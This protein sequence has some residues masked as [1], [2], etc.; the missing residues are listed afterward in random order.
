MYDNSNNVS[1]VTDP[2]GQLTTETSYS[3]GN[4]YTIQQ[5]GFNVFGESLG[6][7]VTLP[8]AEGALAG[9]YT[10][11]HTYTATTGLPVQRHLPRLARRRRAA[12]RDRRPRLR[13]RVR[14]ARRT[15]Q[16]LAA[17]AQNITYN[18]FSQ[19]AQEE[20]GS[21]TNHA[22]ITNTYDPHTG[23][24]TDSQIENTAVSAT[25][26]D[27]T[28]YSYDPAGNITAQTDTRNGTQPKPSASATT[29]STGS[30]RP[31]PP[32]TTAP[33]TPPA[34]SGATVGD[35]I[36]GRRVLDQL[37]IRPARRPDHPDRPLARPAATDTVT[38][39]TYN[40]NGASQPNTLTSTATTG[41]AGNST[42]S[43]TYDPAGNTLTR[44][45]PSGNQTLTWTH[46]GKLATDTTRGGT[47]SYIYD[48]DGNLLLQKD[49][50][51]TTLYLFGGAEQLVL[52]TS[53][54]AIT[55]TRFIALPGGGE[56]VRTGAGTAYNFEITDQHGTGLLTLDHTATNPAWRQYT[57]YGAPRGTAPPL[58]RHQ[59]VPR[60]THRHHHRPGPSS[61]PASTTPPPAGSP[62]STPSST[63]TTPATQR[64]QLRRRQPRHQSD[65]SGLCT[66]FP[67]CN[68]IPE[69][70]S[71][72]PGKT[73][74]GGGNNNPPT[75]AGTSRP[76]PGAV[77]SGAAS[78]T[79]QATS[80]E[81]S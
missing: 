58:A 75:P 67:D 79:W 49:P 15:W 1:G 34:N 57:P 66:Q 47:T 55:G 60:Q 36:T 5:T 64:L 28:S 54:S 29:P 71:H 52:N 27:D 4:A 70:G 12:R 61:A 18:A 31:G 65:P 68:G 3:G 50:G 39:Y 24:L 17:Y 48:A 32:P 10:L 8:S 16:H 6:Q 41:P 44:A 22:Y 14:P 46:D 35:G 59:R 51:Q 69:P 74:T 62:A 43:Y 13:D 19:V 53:T 78:A 72:K 23:A 77:G 7:T 40:G 56:V 45:C 20:I 30:P 76:P 38:T 37:E 9:S 42:A 21:T 81:V 11:T 2:V 26:F 80:V 73:Y 63:P 33:P 25:P